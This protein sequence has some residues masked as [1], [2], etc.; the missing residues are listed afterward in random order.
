MAKNKASQQAQQPTF[1]TERP[2][3]I[4][5]MQTERTVIGY[6]ITEE[7]LEHVG[8]LNTQATTYFSVSSALFVVGIGLVADWLMEGQPSQ[9]GSLLAQFGTPICV[10]LGGVFLFLAIKSVRARSS[11]VARIKKQSKVIEEL[12]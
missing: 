2:P 11:I 6:G 3:Y 7:E 4:N 5:I 12:K 9:Y 10:V 8:N 1:V